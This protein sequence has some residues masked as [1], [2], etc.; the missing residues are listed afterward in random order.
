M[1]DWLSKLKPGVTAK[2]HLI[3]ASMLWTT[4]GLVLLSRGIVYL[5]ADNL[6]PVTALGII[7]GSVKSRYLL[8]RSAIK[9]VERI[10]RFGDHTCVGAVYSWQTWLLVL[11][12]M[13]FGFM[14]RKS[15]LPPFLIGVACT[16]IGWSLFY[17]SRHGWKEIYRMNKK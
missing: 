15:S 17:S 16:A 4:I 13:L 11:A 6:L 5:K 9:G 12:M 2:T 1:P 7:L 10:K 8:D 14:L 3:L